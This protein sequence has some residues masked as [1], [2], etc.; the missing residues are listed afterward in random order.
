MTSVWVYENTCPTCS[1]PLTVGGG[2]SIEYTSL[3]GRDRSNRYTP[4]LSHCAIHLASRPSRA[5]LSGS[6]RRAGS[7]AV[8]GRGIRKSYYRGA[9]APKRRLRNAVLDALDLFTHQALGDFRNDIG[10]R[11]ANRALGHLIEHAARDFVDE[12]GGNHRRCRGGGPGRRGSG[13]R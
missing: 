9:A 7:S 5:G 8:N 3:R 12:V 1:D 6:R 11:L 4:P 10:H 2:V 13:G